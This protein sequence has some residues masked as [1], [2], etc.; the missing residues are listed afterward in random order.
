M[1]RGP[2]VAEPSRAAPLAA[3]GA[4]KVNR[5]RQPTVLVLSGG[6]ATPALVARIAEEREAGA[7]RA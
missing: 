3:G 4:D 5:R 7:I 2:T 1:K 6:N